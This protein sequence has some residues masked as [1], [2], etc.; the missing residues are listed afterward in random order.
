MWDGVLDNNFTVC[1]VTR[2]TDPC[3]SAQ[4]GKLV[5]PI[6]V[7]GAPHTVQSVTHAH[8]MTVTV[9][10]GRGVVVGVAASVFLHILQFLLFL[11]F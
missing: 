7:V 4:L 5:E 2:N 3:R 8:G 11:N 9:V 10:V 6:S 1:P